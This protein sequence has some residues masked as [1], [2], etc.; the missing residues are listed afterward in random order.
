MTNLAKNVLSDIRYCYKFSRLITIVFLG[1]SFCAQAQPNTWQKIYQTQFSK[2]SIIRAS[3]LTD[4]GNFYVTGSA[5]VPVESNGYNGILVMKL[6]QNGDKLWEKIFGGYPPGQGGFC[7][8]ESSDKGCVISGAAD[9]AFCMKFDTQ[10]NLEWRKLYNNY[11]AR[12][13][14]VIQTSDKGY[15]L[16]GVM[17]YLKG[18]ILKID[19]SGIRQWDTVYTS[20]YSKILHYAVQTTDGYLLC[21]FNS[22]TSKGKQYGFVTKI[23]L[24]GKFVWESNY[25]LN[26]L[27]YG[28]ERIIK[29]NNNFWL[30]GSYYVNSVERNKFAILKINSDGNVLDTVFIQGSDPRYIETLTGFNFISTNKLVLSIAKVPYTSTLKDTNS[31]E[32]R[33]IDSTGFIKSSRSFDLYGTAQLNFI[34]NYSDYGFITGGYVNYGNIHI[35]TNARSYLIRLDSNLNVSPISNILDINLFIKKFELYQNYPNPFNPSTLISFALP[36]NGIITLKIYNSLGKEIYSLH[37]F[38]NS[39]INAI[40]YTSSNLSSGIY[41]YLLTFQNTTLT[42]KMVFIK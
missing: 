3:C 35:S 21:G 20:E 2:Q 41:F 24:D 23:N 36:N 8:S 26:N 4:S 28:V 27:S 38:C 37:K 16:C 30:I 5:F 19:S 14:H 13:N 17:D 40:E 22:P 9:T 31:S 34:N 7:I 18:Y 39:G 33:I 15:L 25:F 10:G 42:K 29:I 1:L 11:G 6:N 12:F 32:I